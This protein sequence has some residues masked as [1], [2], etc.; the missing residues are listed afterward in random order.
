MRCL[1][2][3][4]PHRATSNRPSDG[5]VLHKCKTVHSPP[6]AMSHVYSREQ[7]GLHYGR[8]PLGYPIA[9]PRS[10]R[11]QSARSQ[12]RTRRA[13]YHRLGS[14][15]LRACRQRPRGDRHRP[16]GRPVSVTDAP[17][18]TGLRSGRRAGPASAAH[19]HDVSKSSP[20][21]VGSASTVSGGGGPGP[22]MVGGVWPSA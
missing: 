2:T 21:A 9:N 6:C 12:D 20:R 1:V 16:P 11:R 8:P 4:A 15:R 10:S 3:T 14:Q 5:G 17:P 22:V 13:A 18:M 7:S 19:P